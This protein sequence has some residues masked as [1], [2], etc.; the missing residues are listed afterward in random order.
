MSVDDDFANLMAR[1]RAGDQAAIRLFLS[2]FGREVQM[3]VR[4]RLP[5]QLRDQFD[6]SD[7]AQAVWMS[8][9]SE[10]PHDAP[11]FRKIVH[12]RRYLARRRAEQDL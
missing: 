10:L 2:R 8:F 12:L 5:Q 7:L 3:M 4:A 9:F 6:S 11:S 1:A